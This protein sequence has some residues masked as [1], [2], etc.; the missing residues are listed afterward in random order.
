[1][2][3]IYFFLRRHCYTFDEKLFQLSSFT[4]KGWKLERWSAVNWTFE[5]IDKPQN[6][7][8][9]NNCFYIDDE[10]LLIKNL[11]RIKGQN[12]YFLIYPY[13][14]TLC[15]WKIRKLIH[16]YGF[17]FANIAESLEI[18]L[19]NS[20]KP[21]NISSFFAFKM[22]VKKFIISCFSFVKNCIFSRKNSL[23][24]IKCSFMNFW[25][26]LFYKSDLNFITTSIYYYAFPNIFEHFSKRNIII[27]A[28]SYDEATLCKRQG[29]TKRK[30]FVVFVDQYL[31]GHSDFIKSGRSFPVTD[32][33]DYCQKLCGLFNK[34]EKDF[35]CE[36]II[37]AHPKAEYKGYEFEN[38]AI[39][40]GKTNSLIKDSLF[41]LVQT[42]TCFGLITTLKKSFINIYDSVFFENLPSFK[43]YYIAIENVFHCKQLDIGNET[44]V[45]DYKSFITKYNTFY[46]NYNERYVMS[47]KGIDSNNLFY[48]IIEDIIRTRI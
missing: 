47:K 22:E 13:D 36:V 34:I 14:N 27:H 15:S 4:S 25:G 24:I 19:D 41:V 21:V 31:S 26:G 12:C 32:L 45:I 35:N 1:M 43:D 18:T 5:K 6:I 30:P 37:A 39:I 7:D 16:Q 8:E 9:S 20:N 3:V 38:R 29:D 2:K 48:E 11:D 28:Q 46:E 17:K 10:N 44:Q 23:N 33:K 40:S 42:S